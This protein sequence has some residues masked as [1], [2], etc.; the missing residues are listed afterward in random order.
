MSGRIDKSILDD[1][2]YIKTLPGYSEN[3]GMGIDLIINDK[4]YT[5]PQVCFTSRPGQRDRV[6]IPQPVYRR[7]PTLTITDVIFNPPATI[8]F[9]SDKTK[10]VVK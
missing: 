9:W 1:M 4:I 10:T 8:V 3:Q 5:V 2:N 6:I 7:T